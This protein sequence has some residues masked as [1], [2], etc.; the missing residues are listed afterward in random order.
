MH[1]AINIVCYL[2]LYLC[3]VTIILWNFQYKLFIRWF[4]S[5]MKSSRK[6][7]SIFGM[8]TG[9]YIAG[10]GK[11]NENAADELKMGLNNGWYAWF[12]SILYVRFVCGNHIF[13]VNECIFTPIQLQHLQRFL[14]QNA[15]IAIIFLWI[16]DF[17][18][19]SHYV[20]VCVCG[21]N[22]KQNCHL[23]RWQMDW[24]HYLRTN[25]YGL[26]LIA[27]QNAINKQYSFGINSCLTL[28]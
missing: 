14:H 22:N 7:G 4:C 3:V 13:Y 21:N 23:N 8:K 1:F 27:S 17:V 24:L 9:V 26:N 20:C 25:Y 6:I 16:V 10:Y 5:I 19:A 2:S 28:S 15:Q 11:V 12:H 18:A